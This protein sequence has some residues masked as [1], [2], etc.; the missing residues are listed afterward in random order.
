M[1]GDAWSVYRSR[2]AKGDGMREESPILTQFGINTDHPMEQ[3]RPVRPVVVTIPGFNS[4]GRYMLKC[5]RYWEMA[6]HE[7]FHFGYNEDVDPAL[8]LLTRWRNERV[9]E[10]LHTFLTQLGQPAVLVCHSNGAAVAHGLLTQMPLG[11]ARVPVMGVVSVNAALDRDAEM[12][13][14]LPWW[15]NWY[16]PNDWVLLLARLRPWHDWGALGRRIYEGG[17]LNVE[18]YNMQELVPWTEVRHSTVFNRETV[19]EDVWVEIT[20]EA[21]H[22]IKRYERVGL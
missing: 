21:Q 1:V 19:A 14:W 13:F 22:A 9:I 6:G 7:V 17:S 4:D 18:S 12:P 3:H 11:A 16:S 20:L 15:H 10:E 5:H 2:H 8:R